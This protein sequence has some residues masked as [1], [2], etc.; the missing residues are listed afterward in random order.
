[1]ISVSITAHRHRRAEI[2]I[3]IQK[4]N[5]VVDPCD[6]KDTEPVREIDRPTIHTYMHS[7]FTYL[8]S[9]LHMQPNLSGYMYT[10]K[11]VWIHNFC[12]RRSVNCYGSEFH[13]VN[14]AVR[15]LLHSKRHATFVRFWYTSQS[16]LRRRIYGNSAY[17]WEMSEVSVNIRSVSTDQCRHQSDS[18][19][20]QSME[21]CAASAS[22]T[23]HV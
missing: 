12:L 19:R 9:Y 11:L 10:N 23:T 21:V 20:A 1:M 4:K 18:R 15:N 16:F 14:D 8:L 17:R 13:C 5:P 6:R 2:L 3:N 7:L 22:V